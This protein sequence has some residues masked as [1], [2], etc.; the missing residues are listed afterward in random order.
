MSAFLL[1]DKQDP[2]KHSPWRY[3]KKS[4]LESDTL[5]VFHAVCG[6][7]YFLNSFHGSSEF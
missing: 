2:E 7:T 4:E 6:N 3:D 1:M 5:D